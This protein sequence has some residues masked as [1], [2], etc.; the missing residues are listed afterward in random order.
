MEPKKLCLGEH[1]TCYDDLK[2]KIDKVW[3]GKSLESLNERFTLIEA[4][5]VTKNIIQQ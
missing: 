5:R 1:F 3:R 4:A 2:K